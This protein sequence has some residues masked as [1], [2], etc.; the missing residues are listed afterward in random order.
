VRRLVAK[1]N[2]WVAVLIAS[3]FLAVPIGNAQAA[4]TQASQDRVT[5][6]SK[7][8]GGIKSV[9][10]S[11]LNDVSFSIIRDLRTRELEVSTR[12]RK[13][14]GASMVLRRSGFYLK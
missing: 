11:G 9:K 4:W 8:L 10:I 12:F 1:T 14:L 6:T 5:S 2:R 3:G 13:L 7:T